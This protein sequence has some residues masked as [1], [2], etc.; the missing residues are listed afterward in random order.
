MYIERMFDKRYALFGESV[1]TSFRSYEGHVP[2]LKE[3]LDR[4]WRHSCQGFHLDLNFENFFDQFLSS[5]ELLTVIIKNPNHYFRITMFSNEAN[6]L[7]LSHF[8]LDHLEVDLKILPIDEG[9]NEEQSLLIQPSPFN[10]YYPLIKTGNYFA[11]LY[12]RRKAIQAGYS[13]TV[14]IN[15]EGMILEASTSNI[16]FEFKNSFVIPRSKQIFDGITLI[17]FKD[18]CDLNNIH[19]SEVEIHTQ[20]LVEFSG[21]Y[22]LNSVKGYSKVYKINDILLKSDH[23]HLVDFMKFLK[24][25]K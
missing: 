4:L 1:F 2:Y 14:F 21:A 6:D 8:S 11:S 7:N 15:D 17:A 22:L 3:H 5:L 23:H 24:E 9:I 12:F 25:S 10:Q 16:V 19:Y 20:D 13:D 18:F